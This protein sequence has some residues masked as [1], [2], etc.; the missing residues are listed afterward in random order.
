MKK[1]Y[2]KPARLQKGDRVGIVSPSSTIEPFPRRTNRGVENLKK[3]GLDVVFSKNAKKSFGHNAGTPQERAGDINLMFSDKS[4]KAIMCST[5]GL[6][7]NAVLPLLDYEIIKKNQKIFCGYSDITIL[8]NA[9][10]HKTGLVTFN[11]PTLLPT[12]GEYG[13]VHKYTLEY[14]KKVLFSDKPIGVFTSATEYSDENLWWEKKDIRP[15]IMKKASPM[16]SVSFGFAE[17]VLMGGNLNSLCFLGGTEYM[18]D[19]TNSILF[20]EDE[21]ESTAYTERRLHY[22]EQIGVLGKTRGILFARPYQFITDSQ[23]RT[24][25]DILSFFGKKY[26]IPIICDI[27]FGHTNPMLTLPL[28]IHAKIKSSANI[29]QVE[30]VE[31]AVT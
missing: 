21:G 6:N 23:D 9:I 3:I 27:D 15:N 20:L 1:K 30:V 7:A 14:F 22:L 8:N 2:I 31:P 18:P 10:T 11:G 16:R 17:G 12:F 5:G 28:G 25:I 19:F 13:G 29:T 26:E 4:I 24:L